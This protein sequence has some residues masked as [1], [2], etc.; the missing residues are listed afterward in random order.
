MGVQ[1]YAGVAAVGIFLLFS[2]TTFQSWLKHYGRDRFLIVIEE[3]VRAASGWL[4]ARPWF[5]PS[6]MCLF[7]GVVAGLTIV[8]ILVGLGAIPSPL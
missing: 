8:A 4:T 3:G 6:M 2:R 7:S 5:W 1:E